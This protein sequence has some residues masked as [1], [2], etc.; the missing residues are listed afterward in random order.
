VHVT[1]LATTPVKGMRVVPRGE[2]ELTPVG[3][4]DNRRF[5][6]I[7]DR[8]RMV[9]GKRVGALTAAVAEYDHP[10]RHLTIR[11]LDGAE[12]S[13][14]AEVDG[15]VQT[16]FSS[17]SV[18]AQL[19]SGPWSQA[20]SERVGE[21]LRLVE[22]DPDRGGTDRGRVGGVSLVSRASLVE[23]AR[24]AKTAEVD[25]RRFRMLVEIDGVGAHGEDAW[26]AR[27]VRVG[28]ALVRMRGHVGR[29]VVTTRHPETGEVDLPTLE[30]LASYRRDAETTEPLAFGIYGEVVE[31]GRVRVGD[32]VV[33]L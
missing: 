13:G 29:C 24:V 10:T 12:V 11:F 26:V 6:L 27:D 32:A 22:G 15:A 30:L 28:A 20:I 19:V 8:D 1:A 25:A 4:P 9:N 23:L 18:S 31:P 16:A 5:Y 7:D 3:V 14:P 2:I 21:S 17:H 33:A